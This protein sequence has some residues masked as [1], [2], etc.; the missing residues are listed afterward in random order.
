M[1]RSPFERLVEAVT[2][3]VW[4]VC[5]VGGFLGLRALAWGQ[6]HLV[7]AM[8]I[9]GGLVGGAVMSAAGLAYLLF[10]RRLLRWVA[11]DWLGVR[12]GMVIGAVVY[13]LYHVLVPLT[14][15]EMAQ[16][17]GVR[18]LQGALDGALIGAVIGLVTSF[19]S[20]RRLTFDRTGLLRYGLL[21]L[22]LLLIAGVIVLVDSW[23]RLPDAAFVVLAPPAVV[24]LR[25]AVRGLDRRADVQRAG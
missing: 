18:A 16:P 23:V 8:L 14:T 10:G 22:V 20:G 17:I 15:A 3:L 11:I 24:V 1:T 19:V 9:S 2:A 21:Y 4:V 7:G 25:V 12:L 13:S 5:G 6:D